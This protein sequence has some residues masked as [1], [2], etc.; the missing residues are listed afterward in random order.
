MSEENEL[1][2][3][4][5]KAIDADLLEC[6]TPAQIGALLSGARLISFRTGYLFAV[7]R[8]LRRNPR[9]DATLGVLAWLF[10]MSDN[11][12]GYSYVTLW[13]LA[14]LFNRHPNAITDAVARLARAGCVNVSGDAG[15]RHSNNGK[16][17]TIWPAIEAAFSTAKPIQILDA[18]APY[19]RKS[20]A[21]PSGC[22]NMDRVRTITPNLDGCAPEPSRSGAETINLQ[23]DEPSRSSG[24]N[25]PKED[26]PK[27]DS[28]QHLDVNSREAHA[29]AGA[30]L[31]SLEE[32]GAGV[33]RNGSAFRWLDPKSGEQRRLSFQFIER[34]APGER[35]DIL[36]DFA[37]TELIAAVDSGREGGL[38][39]L[40]RHAIDK[41]RL[42]AFK[43]RRLAPAM[44]GDDDFGPDA[45][46]PI[47]EGSWD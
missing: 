7:V 44:A 46:A 20:G 23:P 33:V 16:P 14:R 26:S 30:G 31:F 12:R 22:S 2:D 24:N 21:D 35:R 40:L 10:A 37:E 19:K 28:P 4:L 15:D 5:R 39:G 11:E 42:A 1:Y 9:A 6:M 8:Y 13:R 18:I 29:T 41:G 34:Q 32:Q 3:R 43:R 38:H 45:P 36:L 17:K 27:E 25:S 47:T